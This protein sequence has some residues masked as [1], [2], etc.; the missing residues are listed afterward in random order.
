MTADEQP[1]AGWD[2]TPGLVRADGRP[3]LE[4]PDRLLPSMHMADGVL[5]VLLFEIGQYHPRVTVYTRGWWPRHGDYGMP[6]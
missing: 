1:R 2:V 5:A 4:F 3:H 6:P